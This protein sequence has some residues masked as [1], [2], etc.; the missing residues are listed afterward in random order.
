LIQQVHDDELE[1][2]NWLIPK[3]QASAFAELIHTALPGLTSLST[4]C[5]WHVDFLRELASASVPLQSI[6]IVGIVDAEESKA[7]TRFTSLRKVYIYGSVEAIVHFASLPHLEVL[8]WSYRGSAVDGEGLSK[9]LR[10]CTRL[11]ELA[12]PRLPR[13]WHLQ[14]SS[15]SSLSLRWVSCSDR[16]FCSAGLPHLRSLS[17]CIL[18]L[19][20]NLKMEGLT[21][22]IGASAP[23]APPPSL[24]VHLDCAHAGSNIDAAEVLLVAHGWQPAWERVG[25]SYHAFPT[26]P[27]QQ[28]AAGSLLW[29][30]LNLP[31]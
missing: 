11:R 13:G 24:A 19:Y 8:Q 5:R 15:L 21:R 6:S 28:R 10:G 25:A 29:R 2:S 3:T 30:I 23:A 14:S 20:D 1:K 12:I 22:A 4:E 27:T 16:L 31:S 18:S 9:V 17:V 7:I 26:G